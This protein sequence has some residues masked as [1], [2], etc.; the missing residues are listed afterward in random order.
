MRH[1]AVIF[2]R[3][4]RWPRCFQSDRELVSRA[5]AADVQ[6]E[7]LCRM[8]EK[9]TAASLATLDEQKILR[10]LRTAA[11]ED[12]TGSSRSNSVGSF[13]S[14]IRRGEKPAANPAT[15]R[16]PATFRLAVVR[17]Q[18]LPKFQA[19]AAICTSCRR[20]GLHLWCPHEERHALFA[21]RARARALLATQGIAGNAPTGK[22]TRYVRQTLVCRSFSN[23][24]R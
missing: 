15:T 21:T 3:G 13:R 6:T 14:R 7:F 18:R 10:R 16:H 20:S 4:N 24:V 19:P 22:T 2:R 1:R 17:R 11:A 23:C 5:D 8:W 9:V 12:T